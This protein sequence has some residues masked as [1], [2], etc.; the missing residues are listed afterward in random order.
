MAQVFSKI[1]VDGYQ[2]GEFSFAA[3]FARKSAAEQAEVNNFVASLVDAEV[4]FDAG[5]FW[6]V[7]IVGTSERAAGAT[8]EERRAQE[9]HASTERSFDAGRW[10][11]ARLGEGMTSA[12]LTAPA[13]LDDPKNV[14]LAFVAQ[15]AAELV[16]P[17]ASSEPLRL[18]N[19]RV[20]FLAI[21]FA[22]EWTV[23]TDQ[24]YGDAAERR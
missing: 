4:N 9:L 7:T 20:Y 1:T 18:R 12:G 8:D 10:I 13:S 19:R 24:R 17:N 6:S 3:A 15:G 11:F 22:P 23:V 5:L 14:G 21:A 2:D 16:V